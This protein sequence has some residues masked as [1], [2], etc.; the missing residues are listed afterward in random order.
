MRTSRI[1]VVGLVLGGVVVAA[2]GSASAQPERRAINL[3]GRT[4]QAPFSD[5]ILTGDTLYLSGRL[6]MDPDTG[7]PPAEAQQEARN[8]LDQIQAVLE[9]AGM[10][11]DD[12]V[13]VQVVLFRRGLLRRLQ[14][15]VHQLLHE[16]PA[17]PCVRRR[18]HPAPW[19][20]FRGNG[21]RSEIVD[22]QE[23]GGRRTWMA[24]PASGHTGL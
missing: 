2:L 21:R 10:T 17:G 1:F 9:E 7:Q 8:I 15:G 16:R 14:R 4:T 22:S 11:M 20:A 24:S 5:A 6:G 12:L 18:R 13:T 3:P 23:T 19:R